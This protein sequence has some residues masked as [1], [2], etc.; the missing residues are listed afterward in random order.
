VIRRLFSPFLGQF[1]KD[2][3]SNCAQSVKC[4]PGEQV[5]R[6]GAVK[7]TDEMKTH[8]RNTALRTLCRWTL[9]VV[10]SAWNA[11]SA[12]GVV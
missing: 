3:M 6:S 5:A 9:C 4:S 7:K 8:C 1:I 2:G 12:V 10:W 11:Q